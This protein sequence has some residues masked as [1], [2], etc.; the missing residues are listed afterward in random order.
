MDKLKADFFAKGGSDGE[1]RDI[2]SEGLA[3][4]DM[5]EFEVGFS[6]R[7]SAMNH[8]KRVPGVGRV[9]EY[10]CYDHQWCP[11]GKA[12]IE[13]LGFDEEKD[14]T[15][16]ARHLKASDEYYEWYAQTKLGEDRAVYHLCDVEAKKCPF[17]LRSRDRR[18]V[19]HLAEWKAVSPRMMLTAHYSKEVAY[20][21]VEE[22]VRRYVPHPVAPPRVGGEAGLPDMPARGGTGLDEA[23]EGAGVGEAA[24]P[25]EREPS[26][27]V[28]ASRGGVA[29]VLK[30]KADEHQ[31]AAA[32][33]KK[34]SKKKRRSEEKVAKRKK[35]GVDES[36]SESS[37][38][39]SSS[40]SGEDFRQP[41]TRGG[42]E[43]WRL[44][45]KHP[46]RL[47]KR[48]MMELGRYLADRAGDGE[49]GHW[50]DRRVMAYI[51]QVMLAQGGNQGVG[52]RNQRE[53]V[54][55]GTCLD[56][57]LGGDLALLGDTLM[58][59]LK[60]LESAIQDQG[61]QSARHLEIIPPQSA[62]LCTVG[63]RDQA[64]KQELRMMK[65]R[66]AMI[67]AKGNK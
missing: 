17:K 56:L 13:I 35:R 60:A 16:R 24:H 14:Q 43:L 66:G 23:L 40:S 20:A 19:V 57:L 3:P 12:L 62:S 10:S 63:E 7:M 8:A 27:K 64:A 9:I 38:D 22:A 54:T 29:A 28:V 44:S 25:V 30:R 48:G 61:W 26:S 32:S 42:E 1:W 59:R 31:A 52:L 53:A 55:L 50:E 46:G 21:R 36:D 39:P 67:K 49:Q 15:L 4:E 51:N 34:A 45:R 11:Q 18:E 37:K 2:L 58:Q 6:R 65:L 41:P 5:E 47:L 33:R